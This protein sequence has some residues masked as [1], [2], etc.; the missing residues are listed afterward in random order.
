[1]R[2]RAG[3]LKNT[4]VRFDPP[5]LC[6]VR[7]PERRRAFLENAFRKLCSTTVNFCAFLKE[8]GHE[9]CVLIIA[10]YSYGLLRLFYAVFRLPDSPSHRAPKVSSQ[11]LGL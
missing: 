2:K 8:G 11:N 10:S 3:S 4:I 7:L 5:E 6:L 9:S 1:M